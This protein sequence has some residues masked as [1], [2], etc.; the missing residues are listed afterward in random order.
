M[1]TPVHARFAGAIAA[2]TLLALTLSSTAMAQEA[3]YTAAATMPSPGVSVFRQQLHFFSYSSSPTEGFDRAERYELKQTLQYGLIKDLSLTIDAPLEFQHVKYSRATEY[4]SSLNLSEVDLTLKWRI[5]QDDPR[6]I[7]TTR[8]ALLAGTR[9]RTDGRFSAD[10]HLGAVYTQ[11]LGR[12]GFNIEGHA[13]LNTGSD[14]GVPNF[15]GKGE[16]HAFMGN[17]AYVFR[18]SPAEFDSTS[19][20]AW[21]I[22]SELNTLYETNGDVETRFSP[23]LMYEGRRWGFEIMAQIPV[24]SRLDNR[25][26][27]KL[28]LGF[29]WRYI[30]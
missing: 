19:Q 27:L 29:G 12:H 26:R 10:P 15:G 22:T 25:A 21:Y 6:G 30:F 23:G 24:Y 2:S 3:M 1:P 14:A 7:D 4:D 8:I 13:I 16:S 11:V 9:L 5:Y 17:L 18:I 20:S 28:G